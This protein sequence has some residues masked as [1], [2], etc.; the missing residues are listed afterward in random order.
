MEWFILLLGISG[1]FSLSSKLDKIIG[2]MNINKGKRFPS[3]KEL[4]GKQIELKMDSDLEFLYGCESKGILR[5][6]NSTWL[7]I[8]KTNKKNQKE[9]YY[10]RLNNIKSI[11]IVEDKK[12]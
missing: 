11:N 10:Y 1:Y 12:S 2:N 8:E 7:V 5:E 4:V 9:Q 6:F 3:L